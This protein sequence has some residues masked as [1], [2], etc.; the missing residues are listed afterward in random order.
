MATSRDFVKNELSSF[1][2]LEVGA[3]LAATAVI[4]SKAQEA[5]RM[6]KRLVEGKR[7]IWGTLYSLDRVATRG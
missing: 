2:E 4:F 1:E 7:D 5:E 6:G 3:K